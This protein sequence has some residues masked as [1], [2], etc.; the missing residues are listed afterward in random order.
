MLLPATHRVRDHCPHSA[1]LAA[2]ARRWNGCRT[3]TPH[4][5]YMII[6]GDRSWVE[7]S[8]PDHPRQSRSF[9]NR[10]WRSV[11]RQLVDAGVA[12]AAKAVTGPHYV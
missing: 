1:A 8:V 7:S 11:A 2:S 3:I 10:P 12:D 9:S 6:F 4:Y 5:A